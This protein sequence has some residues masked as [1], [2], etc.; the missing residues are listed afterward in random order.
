M[1]EALGFL[2][3]RAFAAAVLASRPWRV[4]PRCRPSAAPA[5]PLV[6]PQ[7]L[8]EHHAD[9]DVVVLDIRSA[10]DGGGAEALCQGAHPG[11]DPQAITTRPA[12]ASPVTAIRCTCR[13]RPRWRS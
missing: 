1:S 4:V 2:S 5:E 9:A 10:I 12:G 8:N 11:C 13:A 3:R 6:T 7:W